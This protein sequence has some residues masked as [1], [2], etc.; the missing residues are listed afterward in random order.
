M[1]T[2]FSGLATAISG[3]YTS[4]KALDTVSH[5]ISNAD[6]PNYVRQDVIQASMRYLNIPGVGQ[7][8]RG[9]DI[10]EIRQIRD[11]FLDIR[12]RDQ[13][14]IK[15]YWEARNDVFSQVQEI[16]NEVSDTSL[17]NVMDE[18]WD[19][20]EELSKDPSNPI[21]RGLV[22]GRATAF[23]DTVNHINA[24]IDA[25]QINLNKQIGDTVEEIN[26]IAEE[27]TKTNR[28][29]MEA[30]SDGRKA[31]DIRDKRNGL[32][33][34]LSELI[35]IETV[36]KKNSCVDIYVGGTMLVSGTD[37]REMEAKRINSSFHEVYWK[38]MP[39]DM[40]VDINS[41]YMLGLLH[42]RGDVENTILGEN[43][44]AVNP[45]VDVRVIN[46]TGDAILT[47][48]ADELSKKDIE[49][50][51]VEDNSPAINNVSDLIAYIKNE[52]DSGNWEEGA[53]RKIVLASDQ[54]MNPTAEELET[55]KSLGVSVTVITNETDGWDDIAAATNGNIFSSVDS[56]LEIK[57]IVQETTDSMAREMGHI[58][59]Y[60][61]IIPSIKK[62]LNT[63]VNTL[64]RNINDIH[65]QGKTLLG[66]DGEDFFVPIEEG[67]EIQA[68]NIMLNPNLE[69][70]NNIAA[71]ES[72]KKGDGKIAEEII[73]LRDQYIFGNL[74]ADNFYRNIVL[75]LG[76]VANESI[77]MEKSQNIIIKN[78]DNDRI[79][80][81]G[82]SMDEEMTNM[83]KFQH[84]YTANSRVVNAI[85]EMIDN[86]VNK[87]GK[88]GN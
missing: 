48:Y 44:G 42:A 21:I 59:D 5:N 39:G 75:E 15:G 61:E 30:E 65:K 16:I 86:I 55:L 49:S 56:N 7:I 47:D 10:Q 70:L 25:L 27:I 31:N 80:I 58:D 23:V 43:N 60:T 45:K 82:V 1:S 4:Q 8:G 19:G 69:N 52:N 2:I 81:S 78:I 77:E 20:F 3:L 34:R 71:S 18:L 51:I 62:Q 54:K 83:L 50:N 12:Y 57:D 37:Y 9:V 84:S 32:I 73:K 24:G 66:E 68:G 13:A 72:G 36:D 40:K 76:V 33:D 87:M 64:A 74:N 29:I 46:K 41:G 26:D 79:S 67:T 85:D 22:K 14:N 88:V 53:H 28:L 63:F 6:N 17:Q 35:N 11:E 38:D